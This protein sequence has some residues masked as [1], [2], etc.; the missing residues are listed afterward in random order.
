MNRKK[1]VTKKLQMPALAYEDRAAQAHRETAVVKIETL[2]R[3]WEQFDTVAKDIA[4]RTVESANL[5]RELGLHLQAFC[6]H[7]QVT[8][9][10]WKTHCD[11]KLKF[12]F[13]SAK[14]F[15]SV[16]RKMEA[17]AAGLREAAPFVQTLLQA[18]GILILPERTNIQ[19]AST[20]SVLQKFFAK[21]TLMRADFKKALRERPMESWKP[22]DHA[23]FASECAWLVAE[24]ARSTKLRRAMP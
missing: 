6:Q 4:T 18:D 13:E 14:T 15:M 24:L 3:V 1:S 9:E 23:A 17:P 8:F 11:G 21:I 2:N 5:A 19:T 12:S 22:A 20:V 16:A 7:E 10:F